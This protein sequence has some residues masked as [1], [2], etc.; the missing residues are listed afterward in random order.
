MAIQIFGTDLS[1]STIEHAR[2]GIYSS[3]IEK[4]VSGTRLKR[5]FSKRDGT[6]QIKRSVREICTFARQNITAD[7]PFSRLDL[8]SCRNVLI[9]LG[10]QLHKQCIPQFH[11]A[12]NPGGYLILGPAESVGSFDE[13]F[14]LVD[15]RNKIYAKKNVATP[16]HV[17]LVSYRGFKPRHP[18]ARGLASDGTTTA[19][20][21]QIA[22][23]IMLSAY[24]PAAVVIDRE[25]RVQQFRGRTDLFLEH[26]PGPATFNLLQLV[27]PTMVADL[28]STIHHALKTARPARK[29]RTLVKYDGKIREV[30][31]EVVP[32]KVPASDKSWLLVI[33]DETT[34]GT[35]PGKLPRVVGKTAR[36]REITQLERELAASKESLQAIIEEQESTN[37]ELKSANEEIES[38]NEELQS[39]NE[40][41]ETAKEELQSTN[42]ELTTLNEELSN[43]NLEMMQVNSDLNNLLASMQLPIVMVDNTLTV[44]RATPAARQ[45]FNILQTDI[46]RP[47]RELRPNFD[48]PDLEDILRAVIQTASTR[49][50]RIVDKDGHEYSLRVRPYHTNDNRIDGAVITLVDIDGNKQRRRNKKA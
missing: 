34:K 32:F 37:E 33:F 22:D 49:K 28:R 23:R 20:L 29:E 38:S 15:K 11:Y 36:E 5:F 3:A 1:D 26:A 10:P 41:L 8:I 44:R 43:R 13:L 7:P 25:I 16:H 6:Y 4:D 47:L 17:D 14:E 2:A 30:N 27:R 31:I 35:R 48:V 18:D 42:E 40:E 12:L 21:Q 24:A 19:Q 9:Y 45:A 50:R 46:G 39:T